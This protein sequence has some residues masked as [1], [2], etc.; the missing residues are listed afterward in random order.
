MIKNAYY[1]YHNGN[2]VVQVIKLYYQSNTYYK[3]KLKVCDK[4]GN[5]FETINAK[6]DKEKFKIW[7]KVRLTK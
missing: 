1:T 5:L 7:T 3:C 6:V 2:I 4:S